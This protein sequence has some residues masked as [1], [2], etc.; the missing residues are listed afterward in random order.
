[1]IFRKSKK[2]AREIGSS[3]VTVHFHFF[4]NF[5]SNF[6][7]NLDKCNLDIKHGL[8]SINEQNC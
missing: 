6:V 2:I 3:F 8:R 7:A 4:R 1:M 5:A